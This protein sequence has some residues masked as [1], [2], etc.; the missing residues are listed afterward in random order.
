VRRH[1]L[2]DLPSLADRRAVPAAEIAIRQ[3]SHDLAPV[4]HDEVVDARLSH[5]LPRISGIRIGTDRE[6]LLR[7]DFFDP[8]ER[9][10][11]KNCAGHA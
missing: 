10:T 5:L 3:D 1:E 7:H 2:R 4:H 8:H 6:D 11:F 9:Q